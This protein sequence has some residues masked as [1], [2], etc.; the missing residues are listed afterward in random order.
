MAYVYGL[1][2]IDG[3][4]YF[5]IGSTKNTL[6]RRLR[7]HLDAV[8]LG[9]HKNTHLINKVKKVGVEN[10]VIEPILECADGV[11][12]IREYEEIR[13]HIKRGVKLTNIRVD[14]THFE[15]LRAQE[16]FD[17]FILLPHHIH[18]I[19]DAFEYGLKR[20]THDLANKFMELVETM[21]VH[22]FENHFNEFMDTIHE[23]MANAYEQPESD[24]QAAG[25]YTRIFAMLE[26]S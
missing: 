5:Y 25:V 14:E 21:S 9:Q 20:G 26:R 7:Q 10:V 13:A 19:V 6:Q 3:A 8:R 16:E 4:E 11:R 2:A 24:R 23:V 1:R 12:F 22:I 18:T 15:W 17:E